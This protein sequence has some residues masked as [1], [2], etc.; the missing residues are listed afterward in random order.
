MRK[1]VVSFFVGFCWIALGTSYAQVNS[2]ANPYG[3]DVPLTGPLIYQGLELGDIAIIWAADG[4][5][6]VEKGSLETY[7]PDLVSD[8]IAERIL[9]RF[10]DTELVKLEAL[11]DEGLDIQ[12]D[13]ALLEAQA[14][15]RPESSAPQQLSFGGGNRGGSSITDTTPVES[16]SGYTNLSLTATEGGGTN[17]DRPNALINGA[18]RFGD[19]VV[20]YDT[21]YATSFGADDDYEFE[22]RFVRV[23]RDFPEQYVRVSAGD[24]I[25]EVR[26]FQ[27]SRTIG[28]VSVVRSK[29][30]FT[31]FRSFRPLGGGRI[32]I[33]RPS[34]MQVF[35]NDIEV[36]NLRLSTGTYDITE[37][38]LQFGT[39]NV[40]IVIRDDTGREERL[41]YNAFFDPSELD[42][43]D[44]EYGVTVG[45]ISDPFSRSPDYGE[46]DPAISAFYRK[47]NWRGGILG[48][49][50]QATENQQVINA[51]WRIP[52]SWGGRLD[53]EAAASNVDGL[54]SSYAASARY[55]YFRETLDY[56][57]SYSVNIEFLGEDFGSL[58]DV[59]PRNL[60]AFSAFA[61][62]S[63]SFGRDWRA[64]VSG[65]Y[66]SFREGED[67]YRASFDVFHQLNKSFRLQ[68]G[69]QARRDRQTG[70]DDVGFRVSLIYSPSTNW[71]SEARYE[72]IDERTSLRVSRTAD[73]YVG[74]YGLDLDY[75]D[76]D[77]DSTL[78]GA[79]NY[80]GN[81]FDARLSHRLTG[82]SFS[83][84]TDDSQ[85]TLRLG[86]SFSYTGRTAALGRP[87]FDSFA[88]LSPHRSLEGRSVIAGNDLSRGYEARSGM[89]GPAVASR[90]SSYTEQTLQYDVD[91]VPPGYDIG[92]GLILLKPTLNSASR[93]QV[94]SADFVSATG[95][96]LYADGTPIS[97]G[98]GRIARSDGGAMKETSFFTNRVGRFAMI[99]LEPGVSYTVTITSPV[100]TEITFEVP[101]DDGA[102]L[103]LG[104]VTTDAIPEPEE[105]M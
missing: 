52:P 69:I 53:L 36:Q 50:V 38:P 76:N 86:S 99:G 87:I 80:V 56:D 77:G 42:P 72:S 71:Q 5:L 48:A 31:P 70:D 18:A 49:G 44:H 23:V 32:L 65:G 97:L 60:Q 3:R 67:G 98:V 15:V 40:E 25:P 93:I 35:L 29:R 84:D 63:R 75:V 17:F 54:G 57:E 19:Y 26:G 11:K 83:F 34:E 33:E 91:D 96:L 105:G 4:E 73:E 7:L 46:T 64:T 1:S 9:E 37:L 82:D 10:Q 104:E 21:E 2:E 24:I 89:F 39:S 58:G 61:D 45:F 66:T 28:G 74:S 27:A 41:E 51:L 6:F 13:F 22:R 90:L 20:Q 59:N 100:P 16:V 78:G 94:G 55:D 88:H 68:A 81:R 92:E 101:L 30:E 14:F 102:L 95:T 43:G 103:R 47:A 62:Y 8:V 79:V 12:Y 85:T